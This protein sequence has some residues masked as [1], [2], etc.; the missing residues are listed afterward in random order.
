MVSPLLL[1]AGV[2]LLSVGLRTFDH[3]LAQ[4]LGAL[5][6]FV[7]SFLAGYLLSGYNVTVGALCASSWL[8][9]IFGR[10]NF[11]MACTALFTIS[12]ACCGF[13]WSLPS[14]L[15]FR[16]FQ[17]LAGG[18]MTPVAQ[19]ILAAA[20]PPSQRA[21]GFAIYGVAVVLAPAIGPTL[22]GWLSD[23][24][25]WHW[26]FLINV[27]VGLGSLAAV[28]AFLPSSEE[29]KKQRQKMWKSGNI[30]FDF[31]GFLFVALFLGGLELV[32]DRGQEYD[33]FGST[34]IRISASV[35]AAGLLLF[36]PWELTRKDPLIDLRLLV[37]RQFGTCFMI[38]LCMGGVLIATTQFLPQVLQCSV[39]SLPGRMP[40]PTLSFCV[41]ASLGAWSR[42]LVS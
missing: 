3:V 15:L 19:S 34:Y 21:R 41:R 22:G 27:P 42:F 13:A 5:G 6:I 31:W 33:W 7:T 11:F 30:R 37:S 20:F 24:W 38:M 18:G 36:A 26:C 39:L 28:A 10:K 12:S 8:V 25:S 14:L 2:V 16:V 4:K 23:N 1:I 29:R 17:G 40:G 35:S 9:E 32:L